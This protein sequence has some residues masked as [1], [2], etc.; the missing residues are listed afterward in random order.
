MKGTPMRTTSLSHLLRRTT[1]EGCSRCS[2]SC[3]NASVSMACDFTRKRPDWCSFDGRRSSG[4][5]RRRKNQE[6]STSWV[7]RCTGHGR[8]VATGSSN[9]KPRLRGLLGQ[10]PAL[11]TGAAFTAT[12]IK[13][14]HAALTK[15]VLGHYNHFAITGNGRSLNAFLFLVIRALRRNRGCWIEAFRSRHGVLGAE[16]RIEPTRRLEPPPEA[17]SA[18]ARGTGSAPHAGAVQA[19]CGAREAG[20]SEA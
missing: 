13:E 16:S 20:R 10:S 4:S 18:I 8:G 17:P 19:A 6:H 11:T 7:S 5:Y 3:R 2:R 15:K 14:Q 12:Q 1:L 9:A